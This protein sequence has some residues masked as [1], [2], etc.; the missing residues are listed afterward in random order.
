MGLIT[1]SL[2]VQMAAE[3]TGSLVCHALTWQKKEAQDVPSQAHHGDVSHGLSQ[4]SLENYSAQAFR[5]GPVRT[6]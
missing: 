6:D 1:P 3:K 5:A 2:W 4:S